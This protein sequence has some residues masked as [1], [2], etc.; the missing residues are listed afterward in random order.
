MAAPQSAAKILMAGGGL[1]KSGAKD[2]L[3]KAFNDAAADWCADHKK[4]QAAKKA[5]GGT[6][7]PGASPPGSFNDRFYN[8]L[9][10]QTPPPAFLSGMER[11]VPALFRRAGQR[12]TSGISTARSA[13]TAT[14][15][16]GAG[17]ARTARA[18]NT[19]MTNLTRNA[20]IGGANIGGPMG[21]ILVT[22]GVASANVASRIQ[23]RVA[24]YWV[25]FLSKRFRP[26]FYDGVLP[27]P[28]PRV[29]EIK[30]PT[31]SFN[32]K[33]GPG[34]AK[35]LAKLKPKTAVVSCKACKSP[36]C[37]TSASGGQSCN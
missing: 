5:N 8:K 4:Y 12:V 35:D 16:V 25:D 1:A 34:Q 30:G 28:P 13:A 33:H 27:G 31:D 6:P 14:S 3:C 9:N 26:R 10:A 21:G 22:A 20:G 24:R 7:P 11:E 18:I 17:A 2:P 32:T 37:T 36:S 23:G 15:G 29:L 19:R